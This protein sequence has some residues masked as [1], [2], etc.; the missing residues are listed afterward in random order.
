M[1]R[2]DIFIF[3]GYGKVWI[4]VKRY[5]TATEARLNGT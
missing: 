3:K 5:W 1:V 2:K 4:A